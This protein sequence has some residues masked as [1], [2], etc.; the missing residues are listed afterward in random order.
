[1]SPAIH[2]HNRQ[3]FHFETAH[4]APKDRSPENYFRAMRERKS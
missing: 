2:I 4:S 1:M 3:H